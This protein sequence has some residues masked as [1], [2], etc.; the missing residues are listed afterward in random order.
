MT[1]ADEH[2]GSDIVNKIKSAE[3]RKVIV[4]IDDLFSLNEGVLKAMKETGKEVTFIKK[5]NGRV[6]YSWT[7]DGREVDGGNKDVDT[8]ISFTS[9]FKDEIDKL[10]GDKNS[11]YRCV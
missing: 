11:L 2:D 9:P 7:F 6:L 3:D 5:K 10:V 8:N 4:E 1:S